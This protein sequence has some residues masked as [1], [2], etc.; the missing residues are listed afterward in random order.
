MIC[1]APRVLDRGD[2]IGFSTDHQ[3]SVALQAQGPM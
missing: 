3:H 2:L 1:Q